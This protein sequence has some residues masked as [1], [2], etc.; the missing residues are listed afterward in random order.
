MAVVV[1]DTVG[2]WVPFDLSLAFTVALAVYR[3]FRT[4]KWVLAR[5][6]VL[7]VSIG[8]FAAF[9]FEVAPNPQTLAL[10]KSWSLSLM[11][12][13]GVVYTLVLW[14]R[15][16]ITTGV[17][18]V[19]AIGTYAMILSDLVRTYLLPLPGSVPTIYIGGAGE[20]DMI[21]NTG[22]FMVLAFTVITAGVAI[23]R[24][25][26]IERLFGPKYAA[27]F[28]AEWHKEKPRGR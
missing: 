3:R 13:S 21:F 24:R 17:F 26:L 23:W 28:W 16:L 14:G 15:K 10:P 7:V 18:E 25:N 9:L 2:F 6:L 11:L 20:G 1:L 27:L 5:Y 22:I 8:L 4:T 12:G 19:Y